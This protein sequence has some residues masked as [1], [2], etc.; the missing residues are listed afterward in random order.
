[1]ETAVMETSDETA[2]P[3]TLRRERFLYTEPQV[4]EVSSN[5][6]VC[7]TDTPGGVDLPTSDNTP[8]S[9]PKPDPL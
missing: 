1:M 9:D 4:T 2:A 7:Y 3:V 8:S 6:P 5:E